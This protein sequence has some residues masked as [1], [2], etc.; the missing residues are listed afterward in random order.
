MSFSFLLT[1]ETRQLIYCSCL[2]FKELLGKNTC[3]KLGFRKEQPYYSEKAVCI[4]SEYSYPDQYC[5][6]LHQLYRIGMSKNDVPFSK[7]VQNL[8]DDFLM[9]DENDWGNVALKYCY[10]CNIVLETKS[11]FPVVSVQYG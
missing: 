9:V 6:L 5:E 7:V 3:R 10:G 8:V 1:L 4:V 11:K 2:V